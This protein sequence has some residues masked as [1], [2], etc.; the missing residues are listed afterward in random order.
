MA[1]VDAREEIRT[2]FD[3]VVDAQN[4]GDAARLRLAVSGRA[5]A[6][7]IGTDPGE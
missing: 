3:E 1:D 2:A 7:H 6:V 5:G 4:S